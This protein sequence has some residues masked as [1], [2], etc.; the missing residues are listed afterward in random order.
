MKKVIS[1]FASELFR[2]IF[3]TLVFAVALALDFFGFSP[4]AV[5]V[6]VLALVI[7]GAAVFA[8]AVRGI[9]RRDLLDEKFLMS[10]ASV[11]AMIIGEYTEGVAVM[12]FFLVGEYFEH[13]AVGRSRRSIKELMSICP[14]EACVLRPDGRE[15]FV[16][17]GD[18]S[19]GDVIVLR[20]GER[21]PVDCVIIEGSSDV[22]TSA[23]TGESVPRAFG[24]G[25]ALD[26]GVVVI[27]GV[28]KCRA[29]REASESRASRVLELVE[30]ASENKSKE[31]NFITKFSRIYTP[32]V[33]TAAVV[34]AVGMPL[35]GL[36][37]WG[38][39]VYKA[40]MFLVIS[41]PCA[42]VISVPMAFF[43]GIGCAAAN[44]ILY[45]GGNVFSS[46]AHADTFAFDKT[47]TL[48]TGKFSV[49]KTRAIGISEE[50]LGYLAA[51]AEYGS[52]HPI[53]AAIEA[54]SLRKT[55]PTAA[56]E[57]AGKGVIATVAGQR[58]AVGNAAL[59]KDVG[60]EAE[61]TD[62][63]I[64]VARESE[65]VGILEISDTVKP[66]A[67][68]AISELRDLGVRR[69]VMLTGD[70]R[71]RAESVAREIGIDEVRAELLPEDK[72]AAIEA[73]IAES[74]RTVYV[75]DGINDAP[76]LARADAG[77]AMGALG[78]DSAIEAADA[79]IMSDSL[80]K[81]PEMV[82]IARKTLR[83][84]KENIIFALGVKAAV[85]VLS[86]L[87]FA[88]M[89]LAVIADVGV[90]VLAILNSMRTLIKK[91]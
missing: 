88:N 9:L 82:K 65:L 29:L 1:L 35:L 31:E 7:A 78:Q 79:V 28:L 58:I 6:Y 62:G 17:A 70:R 59:M 43:G 16:D 77:V 12:L 72:Y 11:G 50:E 42:L 84:A 49:G 64:F 61:N 56:E 41:C 83:I 74:S 47:G 37:S 48:T 5:A 32:A 33:V 73:L 23:L 87:G 81:L 24:V 34:L 71:E 18:V 10:V 52:N 66:E 91:R 2:I 46:V 85:M 15:E 53:A 27:G 39:A 44:G 60:V 14:D 3:G 54:A 90:A 75:G 55:R 8:D 26:S 19:V 4:A 25:D 36:D 20:P 45:K 21:V 38:G 63:V 13:K 30:N 80:T 76:T 68:R 86:V 69:T 67:A 89:W 51:S 57:I 40:L 22:D